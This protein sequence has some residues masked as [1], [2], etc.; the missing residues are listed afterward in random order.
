MFA[1]RAR[2]E[3]GNGECRTPS[4]KE[5][6]AIAND[7]VEVLVLKTIYEMVRGS[8]IATF[9]TKEVL[10]E[11]A[12]THYQVFWGFLLQTI[13]IAK[14]DI[15]GRWLICPVMSDKVKTEVAKMVPRDGDRPIHP[16]TWVIPK[17]LFEINDD[18]ILS[19]DLVEEI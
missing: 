11:C 9:W 18:L 7:H 14:P 13:K 2:T 16:I 12:W 6:F 15:G 4:I 10:R 3:D 5:L 1:K 8:P 19:L 17:T